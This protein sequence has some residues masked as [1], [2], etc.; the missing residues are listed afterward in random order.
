MS[1]RLNLEPRD[2]AVRY[3][4]PES[5]VS[6]FVN[7]F[8]SDMMEFLVPT[9][10][11][12]EKRED[13]TFLS[14]I[15]NIEPLRRCV[16]I[17]SFLQI[18]TLQSERSLTYLIAFS[19]TGLISYVSTGELLT[20]E[21]TQLLKFSDLLQ[22]M[23]EGDQLLVLTPDNIEFYERSNPSQNAHKITKSSIALSK[24]KFKELLNRC[25]S[26]INAFMFRFDVLKNLYL[27]S[28]P[29]VC[30]SSLL[31]RLV[32]VCCALHNVNLPVS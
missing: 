30:D 1:L 12:W 25:Q 10:I 27:S 9:Y 11:L 22:K 4:L 2:I 13:M 18:N 8:I 3:N 5:F 15:L 31:D 7:R 32:K 26:I 20:F 21:E 14:G 23:S 6:S 24:D 28:H 19:L 16:C 29:I 17:V